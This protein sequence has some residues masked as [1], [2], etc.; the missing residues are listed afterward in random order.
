[1]VQAR[2]LDAPLLGLNKIR[3]NRSNER[4]FTISTNMYYISYL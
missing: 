3:F 1:M 4:S 2:W